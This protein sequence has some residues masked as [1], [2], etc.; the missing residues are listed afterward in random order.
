MPNAIPHSAHG[1]LK[2]NV[3]KGLAKKMLKIGSSKKQKKPTVSEGY[4]QKWK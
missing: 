4:F 2:L 1:M 3:D